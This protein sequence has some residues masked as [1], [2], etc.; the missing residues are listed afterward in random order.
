[1]IDGKTIAQHIFEDV[2]SRR[3]LRRIKLH[4]VS[5]ILNACWHKGV[6]YR[7]SRFR[8]GSKLYID[9]GNDTVLM[10]APATTVLAEDSTRKTAERS[11]GLCVVCSDYSSLIDGVC[12]YCQL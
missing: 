7:K 6:S 12:G 9:S 8:D 4:A 11:S 3:R 1:M 10:E 2:D 5:T